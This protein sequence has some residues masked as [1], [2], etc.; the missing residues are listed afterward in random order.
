VPKTYRATVARPPVPERALQALREG[1]VL[2]DGPTAPAQVTRIR[3]DT[4][5]LTI[6]EGRKRQVRRMFDA[7]GHPVRRLV[8]TRFGPLELGGLPEGAHRRVTAAEL[9]ALA[10]AGRPESAPSDRPD[11]LP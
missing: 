1:I 11:L 6:R 7:V 9:R 3:P 4:F 5:D 10:G 8:R 2:D